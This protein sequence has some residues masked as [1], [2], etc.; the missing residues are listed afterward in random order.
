MCVGAMSIL[1][2]R[3]DTSPA[4]APEQK[5]G[6]MQEPKPAALLS[7]PGYIPSGALPS[8]VSLVPEP[9][10]PRSAAMARDEEVSRSALIMHGTPR[11]EIATQ[12]VV[13]TLP[14]L[15]QTFACAMNVPVDS[16]RTPKL[17][18]LLRRTLVDAGRAT[19]DAKHRYQRTRP[20]MT[21]EKPT[22]TPEMEAALRLDG[23][24]PSGHASIGWAIG[25]VL[26]EVS[27]DQ[28]DAILARG[29]AF[30][31]SRLVC[32]VHWQSDVLEGQMV[33]SA[34]VARLHAEPAFRNDVEAARTEIAALRSKGAV[35]GRN[36]EAEARALDS[37]K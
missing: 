30:G 13:L 34:V 24:Y 1:I 16:D 27:P 6:P 29:R 12:D 5:Q 3:A 37:W 11:W 17:I 33:G 14:A 22:C 25:L 2:A 31:Q 19:S 21:N 4:K 9:P 18:A 36:C 23:S 8:S 32:N 15:A 20:F 7:A 28:A 26:T 35:V 10:S